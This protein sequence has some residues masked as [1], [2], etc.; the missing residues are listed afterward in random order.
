MPGESPPPP[1]RVLF[2][3]EELIKKILYLAEC[4]APIALIGAGGIGK[5][6]IALA[7]LHD[8]RIKQ[9]FGENR[10]F[11]RCDGFLATHNHFLRRFS[12]VIGTGIENPENLTSLRPFFS[13]EEMLIVLD[14]AETVLDPEGPS[15]QEIYADVDELSRSSNICLLITSRIS[16]VPPDCK[17]FEVPMLSM[18][19]ARDTFHRIYKHGERSSLIDN[20]LEQLD[21][22]PLSITLLAAVSQQNKWSPNRLI[23]EWAR[24]RTAVFNTKHSRSLAATIELSLTSPM[25]QELGPDARGFLEAVAFFPQGVNEEN[26]H[27]QYPIIS[28]APK[29][30]DGFRV[31]SLTYR[32]N[33]F[34]TMLAPL[35][36]HLRP[37]DPASSPLLNAAR[38]HYFARLS[39]DIFPGKPGFEE[40]R[41]IT[42]EDVNV[43]H[44]LSVF[45]SIDGTSTRVWDAWFRFMS[46][47]Y[48]HKPRPVTL[49]PKIEALP[50]DHPSKAQCLRDLSRLCFL[51]GNTAECKRLLIYALKLWRGQGDEL[52]VARTLSHLSDANQKIGLYEE[53]IQQAKEA[54]EVFERLGDVV[55]RACSLISLSRLLLGAE[56]LD[57]AEENALHAI[58]LL[59]EGGEQLWVY[60]CHRLLG[61]IYKSKGEMEKVVHHLKIVLEISSALNR[62]KDRFYVHYDLA[63]ILIRQGRFGDAQT[64]VEY[65]KLFAVN[66]TYLLARASLLQ[67]WLWCMQGMFGEAKPEALAALDVFEKL[68]SVK[69]AATA[70]LFLRLVDEQQPG[71]PDQS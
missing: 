50:D 69:E 32:N 2:G 51:V 20:V 3:R 59:P 42:S 23:A 55:R 21:F 44:L 25:F 48:W 11:I 65:T 52:Q 70:R 68:G 49:G 61:R 39:G 63:E 60:E 66:D 4:L 56:Q 31:L 26:V 36:D 35:R 22:H 33:G 17:T 46:Q 9:R 57:A 15:A 1:P 18:E 8:D 19:A 14:N 16:A 29:L 10:R 24:R 34:V 28:N 7:A 67:T 40:A 5:T 71:Q 45:T 54:Y 53:G 12:E 43:E 13:S 64:H 41:W 47:L 27:W 37:K 6:S 58:N 38:E 62:A 30:L